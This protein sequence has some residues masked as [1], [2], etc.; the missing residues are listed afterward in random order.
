MK[1]DSHDSKE[2]VLPNILQ[3]TGLAN[4]GIVAINPDKAQL[5]ELGYK[6]KE[7]PNYEVTFKDKAGDEVKR[8]K[9][10][11]YLAGK[12][13]YLTAKSEFT[14]SKEELIKAKHEFLLAP[15]IKKAESGKIKPINSKGGVLSYWVDDIA[16]VTDNPKMEWFWKHSPLRAS[17]VGEEE[18]LNFLRAFLNIGNDGTL[19]FDNFETLA[20]GSLTELR[21]IIATRKENKITV[22]LTVKEDKSDS[23]KFYQNIYSGYYGRPSDEKNN[24]SKFAQAFNDAYTTPKEGVHY[25]KQFSNDPFILREFVPPVSLDKPDDNK[26]ESSTSDNKES[27]FT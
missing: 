9:I 10:T 7:E 24:K 4:L 19:T 12:N 11:L 8:F 17:F 27:D 18:I 1:A 22:D 23:T 16:K 3:F 25:G 13:K 6:P 14:E 15:E 20:K 26:Q 2:Q 21:E 5:E